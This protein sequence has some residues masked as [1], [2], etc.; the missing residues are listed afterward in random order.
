MWSIF[1]V[2]GAL[3]VVLVVLMLIKC[4]KTANYKKAQVI[5]KTKL[6]KTGVN[7]TIKGGSGLSGENDSFQ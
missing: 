3:M 2:A 6:V 7:E 1:A 4:K 5:K